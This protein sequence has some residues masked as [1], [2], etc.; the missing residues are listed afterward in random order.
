MIDCG[1]LA[2]DTLGRIA[3][4][5]TAGCGPIPA[6]VFEGPADIFDLE[7]RLMELPTN[8]TAR[9]RGTY[10][11]MS[12]FS[13]LAERGLFV[14]DWSDIH[15]VGANQTNAYE[16]IASPSIPRHL[17]ELPDDLRLTVERVRLDVDLAQTE[18]LMI[19]PQ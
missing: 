15:K 3:A 9:L 11:A 1:W 10:G 13:A 18:W 7:G 14:F 8:G 6:A 17:S 4:L 19:D 5:I 2:C 12:S 16:L